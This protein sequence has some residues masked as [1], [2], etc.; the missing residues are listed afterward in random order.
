[1]DNHVAVPMMAKGTFRLPDI[2]PVDIELSEHVL[3][4]WELQLQL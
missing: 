2:T 3:V 4:V 1:M